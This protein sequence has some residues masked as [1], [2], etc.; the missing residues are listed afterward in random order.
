MLKILHFILLVIKNNHIANMYSERVI[1]QGVL[2][3]LH[4]YTVGNARLSALKHPEKWV[5][6]R[7]WGDNQGQV[8]ILE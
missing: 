3:V 6:T 2:C 7:F 8:V 1:N 4:F 5:L